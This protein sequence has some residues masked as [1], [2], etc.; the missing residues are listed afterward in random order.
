[1]IRK[2]QVLNKDAAG[3]SGGVSRSPLQGYATA[4]IARSA[5]EEARPSSSD[6]CETQWYKPVASFEIS[7]SFTEW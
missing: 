6:N 2:R 1:V 4:H 5:F 3:L 7:T